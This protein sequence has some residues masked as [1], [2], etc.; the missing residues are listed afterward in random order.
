[1]NGRDRKQ[2]TQEFPLP[3]EYRWEGFDLGYRHAETLPDGWAQMRIIDQ[4]IALLHVPGPVTLLL[5]R[6]P[7]T[8][9]CLLLPGDCCPPLGASYVL[10]QPEVI[11]QDIRRGWLPLGGRHAKA[12]ELGRET[13]PGLNLGPDVSREHCRL[14]VNALELAIEDYSAN[15]TIIVARDDDLTN[16][17]TKPS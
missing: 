9:P 10:M 12:V 2:P 4:E 1:V 14:A 15:G 13:S 6:Q 17:A 5:G 7:E 3:P 8:P 16:R 11:R